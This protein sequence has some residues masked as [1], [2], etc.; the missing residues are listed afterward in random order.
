MAFDLA[1][2]LVFKAKE[3][4]DRGENEILQLFC[5]PCLSISALDQV[6]S[7][8]AREVK[9]IVINMANICRFIEIR[10]ANVVT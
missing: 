5:N 7:K 8:E 1:S 2:I 3:H 10:V 6:I 9:S 4:F